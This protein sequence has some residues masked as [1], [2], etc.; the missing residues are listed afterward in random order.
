M[1]FVVSLTVTFVN[2]SV[3]G[4]AHSG[5]NVAVSVS[6]KSAFPFCTGTFSL[7]AIDPLFSALGCFPP[8]LMQR[9]HVSET[10]VN[11]LQNAVMRWMA[12][13]AGLK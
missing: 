11:L 12:K 3:I 8:L 10:F 2:A 6:E 9:R 4:G 13:K 7:V 5:V 1:P